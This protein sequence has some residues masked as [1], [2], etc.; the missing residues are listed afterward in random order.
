MCQLQSGVLISNKIIYYLFGLSNF[1]KFKMINKLV[2]NTT[3][4][5]KRYKIYFLN[6]KNFKLFSIKKMNFIVIF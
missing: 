6:N 5:I 4:E 1:A 2:E 3:F